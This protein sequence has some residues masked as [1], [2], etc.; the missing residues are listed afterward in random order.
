MLPATFSYL[1]VF[2]RIFV[3]SRLFVFVSLHSCA[4]RN[5]TG[6]GRPSPRGTVGI[7]GRRR[8]RDVQ[9]MSVAFIAE[10]AYSLDHREGLASVRGRQHQEV[11]DA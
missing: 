4:D 8:H 5:C 10:A 1:F 3:F 11:E 6:T 2:S 7:L 9:Y